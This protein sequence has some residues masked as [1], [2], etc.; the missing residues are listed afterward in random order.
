MHGAAL[1]E[2]E[3]RREPLGRHCAGRGHG[4]RDLPD[5]SGS[6]RSHAPCHMDCHAGT[7]DA[8]AIKE[9]SGVERDA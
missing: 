9:P 4:D 3:K 8:V 7:V 6:I 2:G 5:P 1:C